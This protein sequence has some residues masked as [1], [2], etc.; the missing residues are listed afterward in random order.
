MPDY[1]S[2]NTKATEAKL[3]PF[4]FEGQNDPKD[5]ELITRG[6]FELDNGA[7]YEGQWSKDGLRYGRGK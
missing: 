2:E 3:G 6:P 7:I 4:K 5:V 1:G